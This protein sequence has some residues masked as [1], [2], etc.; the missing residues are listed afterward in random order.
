MKLFTC[1]LVLFQFCALQV[2]GQTS[3]FVNHTEIGP[4]WGRMEMGEERINLSFQT[5]NGVRFNPNHEIGFLLGVDSYPGFTLM[6]IALGWR[7]IQKRWERNSLYLSM[8]LGYGSTW[9]GKRIEQN[10]RQSWYQGGLMINPAIGIRKK[11]ERGGHSFSLSLGLKM[12][13]AS[14]FEGLLTQG[15]SGLPADNLLTSGFQ[16]VWE[17]RYILNSLSLK[18]GLIF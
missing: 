10:Q 9:L 14:F 4:L 12:Q 5:F 13:K 15:L 3:L 11:S 2:I 16:S 18:L 8:D 7:G 17:E 6:P 1:L